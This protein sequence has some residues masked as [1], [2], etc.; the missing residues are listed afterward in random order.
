M[1]TKIKDCQTIAELTALERLN[2]LSEAEQR[3][4]FEK[5]LNIKPT[6]LEQ[7]PNRYLNSKPT[8]LE[9][10]PNRYLNS[11]PTSLKQYPN[12]YLNSKPCNISRAVPEQVPK[13]QASIPSNSAR[14][15][16][17][18]VRLGYVRLGYVRLG[19]VRGVS[20]RIYA[21]LRVSTRVCN[22][23]PNI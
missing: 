16:L 7:C 18:Y 11:K 12:R 13:L 2:T 22:R 15:K 14:K 3:L 17:Q 21:Y 20:T 1:D 23:F 9:Q 8:S 5:N 10:Y 19:Y 4:V 6:S